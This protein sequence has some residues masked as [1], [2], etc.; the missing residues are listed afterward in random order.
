VEAVL[1]ASGPTDLVRYAG[2]SAS[3]ETSAS[4]TGP[5]GYQW[6][7]EGVDI[8]GATSPTYRN[9]SLSIADAGSYCVV[10]TGPCNSVTNFATLT[11]IECLPLSS[12]A[13]QLNRQSG[14][15]EQKVHIT[16]PT[17]FTLPAVQ[18]SIRALSEGARVYNAS[19]DLDGISFV[20]YNQELGPG[21]TADLTIEYYVADRRTPEAQLCAQLMPNSAPAQQDGSPVTID[22]TLRLADGTVLIEFAAVP[23]Q[24]YHIQYSDD[25]LNW[26]TVTPGVSN[27][28]N[29]IQWID[30]GPP[31]TD[32]RPSDRVLRFYRV[33][34]L[35]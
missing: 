26:K 15:F 4:G 30:N 34:T 2:L 6:R 22:R 17:E 35:P 20:K 3:F 12:E 28:A 1:T 32:S 24:I 9:E 18:V 10:V 21:E 13:V 25:S 29:R 8:V 7:K 33:V 31:K 5:F 14:L 27:G 19:G 11:V 23:G 16:N